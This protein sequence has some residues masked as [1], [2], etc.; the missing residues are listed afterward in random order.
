[1]QVTP[2]LIGFVALTATLACERQ[3][4]PREPVAIASEASAMPAPRSPPPTPLTSSPVPSP[5]AQ[6]PEPE[7]LRAEVRLPSRLAAGQKVPLLLILHS[8]GTSAEDI[9]GK[10]DWP[11]FAERQGIAWLAPN[12]PIDAQGRRFWDAGPSCCNFSGPPLD[13]VA[14]LR[15]LLEKTLATS[16]IDPA[17]V[18]V[19]GTSN[20][21]FMAHRF[22]CLA[23]DLIAGIVSV[24]G[25]GP[26]DEP[27]CKPATSLRVLE[28]HGEAD[29]VVSYLGGHLFKDPRL[30]EHASVK[31]TVGDWAMR[32]GCRDKP[33]DAKAIDLIP[34]L[35]GSET[36][37]ARFEA[38]SRGR[39]ELWTVA[40]GGHYLAYRAPAPE[41]IW[42][43]LNQ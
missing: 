16:P 29:P 1:M 38:C 17:R 40:G 5:S 35:P 18:F 2:W 36:R 25:A 4:A 22:A 9:A 8:L 43:F 12:G 24:A 10:T 13:H 27:P 33:V 30:P 28:I 32:L 37:V 26:L 31:R 42:R 41:I 14:A 39:V 34:H 15:A 23:P 6:P 21:G 3:P 19:G 20:G 11:S 7:E